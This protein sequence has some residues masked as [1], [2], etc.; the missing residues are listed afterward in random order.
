MRTISALS[1]LLCVGFPYSKRGMDRDKFCLLHA[2][3]VC[4]QFNILQVGYIYIYIYTIKGE[5]DTA[6]EAKA[7]LYSDNSIFGK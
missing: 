3:Y 6:L 1:A 5:G 4:I 2:E 7:Q